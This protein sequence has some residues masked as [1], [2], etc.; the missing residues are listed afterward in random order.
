MK[1]IDELFILFVYEICHKQ[2]DTISSINK[3]NEL[4]ILNLTQCI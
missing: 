2:I 1:Y 4:R 3:I